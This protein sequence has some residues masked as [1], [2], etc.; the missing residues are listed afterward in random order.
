MNKSGIFNSFKAVLIGA[1]MITL[2]ACGGVAHAGA[3]TQNFVSDNGRVFQVDHALS[4]DRDAVRGTIAVQQINGSYQYFADASGGVW[5]K[6]LP[7]LKA[8]K[9]VQVGTSNR[10][11]ALTFVSEVTCFSAS[12]TTA[13]GWATVPSAEYFVDGCALHA[14]VKAASN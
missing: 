6:V 9:W 2:A 10:F 11:M 7:A 8:D 1:M 3:L 4:V 13:F 14:K 5:A 12:G